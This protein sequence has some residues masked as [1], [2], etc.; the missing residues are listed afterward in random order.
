[1]TKLGD[2]CRGANVSVNNMKFC[3]RRSMYE[4][5]RKPT[6]TLLVTAKRDA[7][8][9]ESWAIVS[10]KLFHYLRGSGSTDVSVEIMDAKFEQSP[11]IHACVPS[12][13]IFPIWQQV[14][15]QIFDGI[16]CRGV[17]TIGCFR[18]G[19]HNDRF[20]CPPTIL[21]GVDRAV[22]R[23]WKPVR[24]TIVA[25]LDSRR[26]LNVAVTI[27]KDNKLTRASEI[28][29][30]EGIPAADC[31]KDPNIGTSLSPGDEKKHHGTMGGWV[32]LRNPKNGVW[33]AFAITCAHCCFPRESAVS[34]EDH[35]GTLDSAMF[36]RGRKSNMNLVVQHWR[37]H[38]VR[39]HDENKSR[40]LPVDSPSYRDVMT[41]L[42]RLADRIKES[43][44]DEVYQEVEKLKVDETSF[45]MPFLER[46]WKSTADDITG[47]KNDRHNIKKFWKENGDSSRLGTVFAASGLREVTSTDDPNLL[48]IR[49]WALIR[50]S[51]SRS[52]GNNRVTV[53]PVVH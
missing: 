9:Q 35:Q 30:G 32:E 29:S 5:D 40:L 44:L 21:L 27:R 14:A 31:R 15:L 34:P 13:A 17:F 33:T 23:D 28:R 6:F 12:D 50:V 46:Q 37:Q 25:I 1:M 52:V 22:K 3:G 19:N 8:A 36:Q 49:D 24:D 26:L 51:G 16:D 38:G 18:I 4:P 10:R 20:R 41:T 47:Y 48:S 39:I 11:R 42:D 43:E 45:V 53:S 2:I 7:S